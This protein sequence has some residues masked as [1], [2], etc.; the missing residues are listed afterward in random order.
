MDNGEGG[1]LNHGVFTYPVLMAA[2]ILIYDSDIVPV[3][4]DQIQHLEMARDMAVKFNQ[5]FGGD[6]L[7]LPEARVEEQVQVIPGTDGRKM[8]KSYDNVIEPL[9]GAK[10]MRKQIMSIQTDSTPM[11][12]PL[13]QDGCTML[14]L[15]KHF[16]TPEE[17]A[18]LKKDYERPDFGYGHAKQALFEKMD[19]TFAPLRDE[20]NALLKAPDHLDAVLARGA[21]RVMPVVQD[22]MH[23]VR[24][25]TGLR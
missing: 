4:K 5:A 18:A 2:D 8:S 11:H 25:A 9:L 15:Y 17:V 13:T 7:K 23:R 19:A 12:Q 1:T 10:K 3:G 16:A 21:A 14:A 24:R 6:F 22:V 20:Y